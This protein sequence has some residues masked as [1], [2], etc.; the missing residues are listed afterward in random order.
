[1]KVLGPL[2]NDGHA[3][4]YCPNCWSE[5]TR[6]YQREGRERYACEAC[7]HDGDRMIMTYPTMRY[8]VRADREL[9]HYSVGAVIEH[10]GTFLLFRRRLFPFAYT[11]VA[12]HWDLGDPDPETA[13]EREVHEESG[14]RLPIEPPVITTTL[15]EP[16][17]RGADVHEWRLFRLA[18]DQRDVTLSDEADVI[19]WYSPAEIRDLP[20]TLPA[21]HFLS[22]LGI[23]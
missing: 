18:T 7:G 1:M 22:E 2:V 13:I 6:V 8:E 20:L 23:V 19:G 9:L 10:D 17:R 21:E 3:H 4:T 5:R 15:R 16:C 11:I 14:L 12:G